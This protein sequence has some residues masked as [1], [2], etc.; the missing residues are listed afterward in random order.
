MAK[1]CQECRQ[2][3]ALRCSNCATELSVGAKFCGECGAEIKG[4]GVKGLAA[5]G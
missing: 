2:A 5:R 1:F 4:L 3:F